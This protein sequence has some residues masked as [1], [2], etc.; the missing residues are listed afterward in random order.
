MSL[1]VFKIQFLRII[2]TVL[3]RPRLTKPCVPTL[4]RHVLAA[5]VHRKHRPLDLEPSPSTSTASDRAHARCSSLPL[6][7]RGGFTCISYVRRERGGACASSFVAS[8][9]Q[10]LGRRVAYRVDQPRPPWS[11]WPEVSSSH[12]SR[13]LFLQDDAKA[14]QDDVE[15]APVRRMN[16]RRRFWAR[17]SNVVVL[18]AGPEKKT[19]WNRKNSL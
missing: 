7:G 13:A 3:R 9:T 6:S 11:S 5:F 19:R 2:W 14:L 12:S 17:L 18:A 10:T 1:S 8:H 4:A 16:A 15:K